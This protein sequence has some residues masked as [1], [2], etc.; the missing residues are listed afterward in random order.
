MCRKKKNK[1]VLPPWLHNV[2][3]NCDKCPLNRIQ[4][5][6]EPFTI[7]NTI[8]AQ[9]AKTGETLYKMIWHC[10]IGG[11]RVL[12][13]KAYNLINALRRLESK[14]KRWNRKIKSKGN[15]DNSKI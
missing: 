3:A 11:E 2:F 8:E 4:K 13:T 10:Q 14:I 12:I 15:N 1:T 5:W 7:W 6:A 9:K